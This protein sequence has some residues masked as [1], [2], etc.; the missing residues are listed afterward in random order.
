MLYVSTLLAI[1]CSG[2]SFYHL[3]TLNRTDELAVRSSVYNHKAVIGTRFESPLPIKNVIIPNSL[4]AIYKKNK[5]GT[6][7]LLYD[8]I[9][10]AAPSHVKQATAILDTLE[11]R[12]GLALLTLQIDESWVDEVDE[13]DGTTLRGRLLKTHAPQKK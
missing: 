4:N 3:H 1:A 7:N 2:K 11:A 5:H 13:F 12:P 10:G 6:I 9:R 8:I